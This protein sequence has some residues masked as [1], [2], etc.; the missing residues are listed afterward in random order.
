MLDHVSGLSARGAGVMGGGRWCGE[1][2]RITGPA[3]RDG[4]GEHS[5]GEKEGG[6]RK[7]EGEGGASD[8]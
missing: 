8:R 1:V 2:Q 5:L 4:G 6:E 7:G 3:G